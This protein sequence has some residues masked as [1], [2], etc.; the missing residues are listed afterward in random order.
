[1]GNSSDYFHCNMVSS[2]GSC[3]PHCG[4]GGDVSP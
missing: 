3:G 2:V 4:E 1:M